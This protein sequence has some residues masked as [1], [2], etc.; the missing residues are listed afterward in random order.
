LPASIVSSD[1]GQ[2]NR[3]VSNATRI[4]QADP[5]IALNIARIMPKGLKPQQQ[6]RT[7]FNNAGAGNR[8]INF[9][10]LS[11]LEQEAN[12]SP[13]DVFKQATLYKVQSMESKL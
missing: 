11:K 3:A 8:I 10:R 7:L 1:L 2:L 9:R 6:R 5:M 13:T 4:L 12:A